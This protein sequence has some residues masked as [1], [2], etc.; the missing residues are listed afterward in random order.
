MIRRPPR[1][2]RT[3]TLFPYTTR[4]RSVSVSADAQ[5][6][7]VSVRMPNYGGG[8]LQIE[9][10][11]KLEAFRRDAHQEIVEAFWPKRDEIK[12]FQPEPGCSKHTIVG[13]AADLEHHET[14][15]LK[16]GLVRE[17]GRAHV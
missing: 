11:A 5:H 12:I 17:I 6:G 3:D 13:S 8:P 16:I 7:S 10:Q 9:R 4:F 14:S 1:S 15:L 2:T